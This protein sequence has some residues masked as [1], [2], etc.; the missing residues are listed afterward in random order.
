MLVF[1]PVLVDEDEAHGLDE[2]L[3]TKPACG[4]HQDDPARWRVRFS[5]KLGADEAPDCVSV[6]LHASLSE[7]MP[8]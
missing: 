5:M 3:S 6:N 2:G 1:V 4:Q 8:A 7:H